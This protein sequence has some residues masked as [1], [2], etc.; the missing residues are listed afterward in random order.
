MWLAHQNNSINPLTMVVGLNSNTIQK[1]DKINGY[2][3]TTIKPKIMAI[4][5]RWS[6]FRGNLCSKNPNG[7]Y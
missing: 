6:L 4:V 5:E 2:N 3:Q 7:S 1:L